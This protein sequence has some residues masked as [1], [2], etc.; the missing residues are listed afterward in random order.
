MRIRRF[1]TGD[2]AALFRVYFTAIHEV[3]CRDYAPE[4]IDAWAPANLDPDLWAER[5]RR[6]DPFVAESGGEIVGYADVQRNGYIDH[7][8]VSGTHARQGIGTL[9]MN[10][11]HRQA[12]ELRLATLTSDVSRTAEPFFARHGFRVVERRFP[13]VRGVTIPNAL[14]SR[15]LEYAGRR[16]ETAP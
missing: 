6:I 12:R 8:F 10:R 13:V 7:F 15:Q 14:M 5:V 1:R 2:E 9:L 4:Q 3:A 16:P 11:L